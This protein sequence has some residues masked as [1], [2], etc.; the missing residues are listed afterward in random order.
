MKLKNK[1]ARYYQLESAES[2]LISIKNPKSHP[3]CAIPTGAGKTIIISLI[4]TKYLEE[5]P[6]KNVLVVSHVKEI[7][8]QNYKSLDEEIDEEIGLYSAGLGRKDIKRITVVGIQS[9]RNNPEAFKNI[10]LIIIDECHLVSE[11]DTGT[12]RKFLSSFNCNY[13]GLSATPFRSSGYIHLSTEALF[14]EICYNLNSYDNFNKL[15]GEGYLS[16][17][18]SKAT[19]LKMEI[20]KGVATQAGDWA[21]NDLDILFNNE[22]VTNLA[23][24]ETKAII[25]SGKYKK[26]LIFCINILH[27]ERVSERLN[28]IGIPCDFIHS[29]MEEDR[30][31]VLQSFKDGKIKALSNVNVLTTGLDVPDIDMIVMLRPTKSVSLYCQMVGRGLRVHFN[32]THCLVLDFA[33]NVSSLGPVNDLHIDQKGKPQKGGEAPVKEC[34]NCG[35]LN[36]TVAKYCEACNYKFKFKVKIT[37]EHA[38]VDIVK[39][40]EPKELKVASVMYHR[41]K[42]KNAADSIRIDYRVGLRK[43][44]KWLALDSNSMYAAQKATNEIPNMLMVGE[45]INGAYTVDSILKNVHKFKT[46]VKIIVDVNEKY[47]QVEKVLYEEDL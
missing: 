22:R 33:G 20:P 2:A 28:E 7:L 18:Y 29:Q 42:K 15:V 46:P 5:N 8:E 45:E 25:E 43:F 38:D 6:D 23:L 37:T 26:I 44:S 30:D 19:D 39:R 32:K 17:L 12:Y 14:T 11:W 24:D 13:I 36:A 34:P 10:G 35:C 40:Q 47:P 4:I 3:I 21:N 16:Q 1:V 31:E 41:H 27:S 9:G